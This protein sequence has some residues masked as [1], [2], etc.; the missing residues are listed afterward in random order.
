MKNAKRSQPVNGMPSEWV[1][2]YPIR[3]LSTFNR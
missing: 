2:S 3:I 1:F